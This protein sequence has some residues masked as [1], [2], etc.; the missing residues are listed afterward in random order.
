MKKQQTQT[1][2]LV[3]D[4]RIV[5]L[6][7]SSQLRNAGWK[8]VVRNSGE[9]A[10][11]AV[12]DDA[13]IDLVLMDI[14][15]GDGIDGT[16]A[17]A[18]ILEVRRLPVVFLTGHSEREMVERVKGIT[19][20][21]YVL[22]SSGEFVLLEAIS[23]ALELFDSHQKLA[24]REQWLNAV[25]ESIPEEVFA[26]RRDGTYI[27]QNRSSR[28]ATGDRRSGAINGARVG[29]DRMGAWRSNDHRAFQGETTEYEY[30]YDAPGGTRHG[31]TLV[32]PI[33]I[34]GRIDHVIGVSRDVTERHRARQSLQRAEH[35]LRSLIDRAPIGIIH[36]NETGSIVSANPAAADLLGY[37]SQEQALVELRNAAQVYVDPDQWTE[38]LS[39][40]EE[41]GEV[42]GYRFTGRRRDGSV[43]PLVVDARVGQTDE[44]G[45][46]SV[47]HFLR[48]W[49]VRTPRARRHSRIAATTENS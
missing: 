4:E 15:L 17:A 7:T 48:E 10:I 33:W 3:E 42:S 8:V 34:A 6:A 22:K 1:I 41:T 21:G 40:L 5:A 14:D 31:W 23:M 13:E 19:R 18:R 11:Q 46:F 9:A 26:V 37:A 2:L 24:M 44:H 39:R 32:A 35:E 12:K 43:V 28:E 47:Y 49:I 38:L 45:G 36:T 16:E 27:M 29:A 30:E 25:I 20:Y